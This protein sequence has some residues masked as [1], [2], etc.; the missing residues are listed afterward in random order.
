MSHRTPGPVGAVGPL[1]IEQLS[2]VV[3]PLDRLEEEV[4][5]NDNHNCVED[6]H[7]SSQLIGFPV[8]HHFGAD[9]TD[10]QQ[11]KR[12]YGDHSPGS[13]TDERKVD[14]PLVTQI[15]PILL[16]IIAETIGQSLRGTADTEYI[17]R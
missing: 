10:E 8:F 11:V 4:E 12:H 14:C 1:E 2:A 17:C 3:Q 13:F 7:R 15:L 6:K 16:Q 9:L 5:V